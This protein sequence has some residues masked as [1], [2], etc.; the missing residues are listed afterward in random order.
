MKRLRTFAARYVL[1]LAYRHP[2]LA[3]LIWL[4]LDLCRI[5]LGRLALLGSRRL[6]GLA[7]RLLAEEMRRHDEKR[8]EP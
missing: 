2:D 7:E 6:A 4:M 5:K 1:W 3:R 8:I